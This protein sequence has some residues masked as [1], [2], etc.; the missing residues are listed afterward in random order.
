MV[1]MWH[2]DLKNMP[3]REH[4]KLRLQMSFLLELVSLAWKSFSDVKNK[5]K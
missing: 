1:C 2:N 4:I 3:L 5:I